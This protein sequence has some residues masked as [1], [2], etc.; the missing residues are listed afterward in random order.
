MESCLDR[1]G[2]SIKGLDLKKK[3]GE[4]TKMYEGIIQQYKNQCSS[5]SDYKDFK[6]FTFMMQNMI[7]RLRESGEISLRKGQGRKPQS[8]APRPWIFQTAQH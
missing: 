6:Y 1:K 4:E 2:A 5:L 7:K 3:G 8:N